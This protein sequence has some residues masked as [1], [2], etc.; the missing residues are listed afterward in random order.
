MQ[1]A[2]AKPILFLDFDR[3]LFDTDRFYGWL[4]S[5]RFSRILD[6]VAGR[7]APPDFSAMLYPD[8]IP[9]LKKARVSHRLVLVSYAMNMLLQRKKVRGSGIVS[10]MDDL[11]ISSRPKS[12]EVREYLAR[13]GDPGW[14][15]IFVDDAPK[16]IDDMKRNEPE[17]LCVRIERRPLAA[18]ELHMAT[19]QPDHIVRNLEELFT[20][21]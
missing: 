10:H 16:N 17:I 11:I 20:I 15:H 18:D 8:T 5:E 2:Q 1:R 13:V 4:G 9:F 6:L 19:R 14:Q 7:I 21:L 3:T 12:V